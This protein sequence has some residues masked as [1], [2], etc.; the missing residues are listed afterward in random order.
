MG[1]FIAGRLLA[2]IPVL[3]GVSVVVFTLLHF[4]P[5]DVASVLA[6]PMA[7]EA[8]KEAIRESLGLNRPLPVQFLK[9][10]GNLL[11]GDFGTSLVYKR[12]V[13]EFIFEKFFNTA[14]MAV[15]GALLACMIGITIG[16]FAAS[17]A[18][19]LFDRVTMA[20]TMVVGSTPLFWLG[21]ILVLLFALTWRVF[22]AT[23]MT[24]PVGGGGFLDV[25]RHLVLPAVAAAMPSAAIISRTARACMIET[26]GQN[27]I[28]VA[29]AKGL[30]RNLILRKHA[31]RNALPPIATV[32]GLELAFLLTG[33]FFV[34]VVFAWPG[35]GNA[36]YYAI[37]A[38]DIP[39]VQAAVLL[40]ALSFVVINLAVDVLN[41]WLDP[42]IRVSTARQGGR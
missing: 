15:S 13:A 33:V 29:R 35:L 7:S 4:A 24:S 14:L 41:A 17:K 3:F 39:T 8:I 31:F 42:R 40:I 9:W 25:V 21:L 20:V 19:S 28:R 1:W 16:I 34:E 2:A 22:P 6:G 12:P 36:L 26:L 10:L 38:H 32:C 37:I 23:G 30:R 27:Y 5:G 18:H 11:H